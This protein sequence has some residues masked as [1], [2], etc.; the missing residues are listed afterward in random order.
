ME[1][2]VLGPS[3]QQALWVTGVKVGDTLSWSPACPGQLRSR[4]KKGL[5]ISNFSLASLR[6]LNLPVCRGS[7]KTRS[8]REKHY[9]VP[10]PNQPNY[11][12]SFIRTASICW[13]PPRAGTG[14]GSGAAAQ[15]EDPAPHPLVLLSLKPPSLPWF[16][17]SLVSYNRTLSTF[18]CDFNLLFL[19]PSLTFFMLKFLPS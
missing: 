1:S 8:W 19:C 17:F 5:W 14:Q 4:S 3:N 11:T 6:N 7:G 10:L 2:R 13:G 15:T 18:S 12:C 9:E 16:P